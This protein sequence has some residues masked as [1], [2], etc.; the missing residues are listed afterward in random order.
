MR[1]L[2]IVG[3]YRKYGVID[4]VVSEI[5]DTAARCGASTGK[6]YLCDSRIEFCTNC[7]EC[8]QPKGTERVPCFVHTDDDVNDILADVERSDVVVLGAPVNL[9]SANAL[10]QQ[11]AERC[12]GYY[13]YPWGSRMPRLRDK[14]QRRNAILVSSSAAPAF[15]NTP[16]LGSGALSTLKV[17]SEL[18]G[19]RVADTIKVGLV[20]S[21][22]FQVPEG[23][24]RRA[25][26]AAQKLAA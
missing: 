1:F 16:L 2:G 6:R 4:T 19:A 7:R 25:R 26:Q 8:V 21:R 13:Y 9:G 14:S 20:S 17:I 18:I 10:T 3:S 24:L 12:I 22:D 23:S 5:L 11:F 15:M